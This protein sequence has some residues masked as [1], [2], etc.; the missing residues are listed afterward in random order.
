M[1]IEAKNLR[2][3]TRDQLYLL[4]IVLLL[5][6]QEANCRLADLYLRATQQPA[7]EYEC[8]IV[9]EGESLIR[10]S[11][12][13]ISLVIA[14]TGRKRLHTFCGI[15][16]E[17]FGIVEKPSLKISLN[18][19]SEWDDQAKSI[20][21]Y[22]CQEEVE[23]VVVLNIRDENASIVLDKPVF[24]E[25]NQRR[26]LNTEL[27]SPAIYLLQTRTS[28]L[29]NIVTES[30]P[31]LRSQSV[32]V[33][34]E[35]VMRFNTL[36]IDYSVLPLDKFNFLCE[37]KQTEHKL[38]DQVNCIVELRLATRNIIS[39]TYINNIAESVIINTPHP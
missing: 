8:V 21:L 3:N 28:L 30:S 19:F 6:Q 11:G 17:V 20:L 18:A 38:L 33:G 35:V 31:Y 39:I 22:N 34:K 12:Q 14:V 5:G 7:L 26:E 25:A 10:R 29:Y 36:T 13:L 1:R 37:R 2:R 16:Q 32:M 24:R 23:R 9:D 15:L 4:D 27:E